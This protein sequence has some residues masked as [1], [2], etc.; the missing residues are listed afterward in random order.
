MVLREMQLRL[1]LVACALC[2]A[3]VVA[4]AETPPPAGDG[5]GTDQLTLPKGRLVLS[6]FVEASLVSGAVFKPFSISP[7]IW[8]GVNDDL[9][10]GLVHSTP[11][12]TGFV[13]GGFG[14]S[15]CLSGTG[16][17][18]GCGKLYDR[19][20]L[21]GRYKLK[22]GT[23]VWAADGGLVINS[24]DAGAISLKAGVAGRWSQGQLAVELEPALFVGLTK[25]D[26]NADV[27]SLPVA[28]I[29]SLDAKLAVSAQTGLILPFKATGDTY[30]VPLSIGAHYLV[31]P[32]LR[33]L[34]VFSLPRLV[35]G[36]TGG[37]GFDVRSITIGGAYAL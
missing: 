1:I 24:I 35:G 7:D 30:A 16:V 32:Q 36:N 26:V 22:A 18:S 13:T 33:L 20:A 37:N 3:P 31:T 19:L 23:T 34:F 10:V 5:G 17:G 15:L 4:S 6:A 29:Y 11:G 8:Y 25:R 28:G 21:D 14:D 27:L 12:V 2:A 9:T